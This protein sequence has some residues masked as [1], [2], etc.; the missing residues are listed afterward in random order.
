MKMNK[1]VLLAG[2]TAGLC[3][4][5][6]STATADE[7]AFFEQPNP[8]NAQIVLTDENVKNV[9]TIYKCRKPRFNQSGNSNRYE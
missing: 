8:D 4:F 3:L 5:G 9:F 7:G 6:T 1:I 2:V